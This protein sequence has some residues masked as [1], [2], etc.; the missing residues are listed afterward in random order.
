[1]RGPGNLVQLTLVPLLFALDLDRKVLA[2]LPV[3]LVA[4]RVIV[5]EVTAVSVLLLVEVGFRDDLVGEELVVGEFEDQAEAWTVEV[6]HANVRQYL[7]HFLVAVCDGLGER[8]VLHRTEPEF[9]DTLRI[10]GV[11]A[12]CWLERIFLILL[13]IL[14]AGLNFLIRG[15][16]LAVDNAGALLVEGSKLGEELLLELQ[17]FLLELGLQFGVLLLDALEPRHASPD[18]RRQRLNITRGAANETLELALH[19]RHEARVL[20]EDGRCGCAVEVL[21]KTALVHVKKR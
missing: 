9:W 1:M 12:L 5:D 15:L 13:L 19:H 11:G 6:L 18:R 14:F 7:Q 4:L 10:A 8:R 16:G 2:R 17:H 3:D 20:C 21:C